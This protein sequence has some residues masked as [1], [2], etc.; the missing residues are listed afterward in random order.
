MDEIRQLATEIELK[1][2]AQAV[3]VPGFD[4]PFYRTGFWRWIKWPKD[5][6][7]ELSTAAGQYGLAWIDEDAKKET[8]AA[9]ASGK[10]F[11]PFIHVYDQWKQKE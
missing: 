3:F 8:L 10:T 6:N 4:L 11:P 9:R 7:V 5:F 1:I 2:R